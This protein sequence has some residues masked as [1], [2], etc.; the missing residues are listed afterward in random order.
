MAELHR[1]RL[2]AVLAADPDLEIVPRLSSQLHPQ[3]DE[4]TD[5]ALIETLERILR[6]QTVLDV[7]RQE[8][9]G[10]IA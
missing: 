9:A 10:I 4:L 3:L 2:S 1:A 5:A 6:Q 7:E 8:P